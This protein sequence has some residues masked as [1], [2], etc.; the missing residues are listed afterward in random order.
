MIRSL[1][2]QLSSQCAN[3]PKVLESLYSSCRNGEQQPT[4]SSLLSALC[5]MIG[6]FEDV[7]V[8][9]DA[10]DECLERQELLASIQ[11]LIGYNDGRIHILTTSRMEK[12]IEE[13][14]EPFTNNRDKICIR[15]MLIDNDIRAYVRGKLQI[16]QG[17][18]KW[19]ERPEVQK[20]IEDTLMG[21]T[22]GM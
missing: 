15:S 1:I 9:F 10:L 13:S 2:T 6:Q 19:Q 14:M 20:E 16:D 8:I 17:L 18:K 4:E 21:K 5:Q 11:Q 7:Y 3:T 22:D 12:D